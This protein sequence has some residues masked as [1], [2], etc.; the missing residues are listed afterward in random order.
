MPKFEIKMNNHNHKWEIYRVYQIDQVRYRQHHGYY[1]SLHEAERKAN[2]LNAI[3]EGLKQEQSKSKHPNLAE[4]IGHKI[5]IDVKQYGLSIRQIS[6]KYN[7]SYATA[8]KIR[9]KVIEDA[10]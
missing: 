5:L 3:H 4:Q 9:R 8:R 7:I 6:Q 2:Q 10:N 1:N